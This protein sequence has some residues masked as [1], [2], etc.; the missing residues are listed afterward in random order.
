MNEFAPSAVRR[1]R[2]ALATIFFVNGAIFGSWAPHIPIV[3]ERLG[4]GPALLGAALLAIAIGALVTMILGGIVMG[5][6]GSAWP[7]QVST[8]AFCACL[9]LV[10]LAPSL[11]TLV[12]AF[13]AFGAANGIMDVAM[14]AHGV[15]VERRLGRAVMSSFHGMFSL[16]GLV[17]AGAGAVLLGRVDPT[18]HI[19][20]ATAVLAVLALPAV[21][22]LL[23]GRA[24]LGQSGAGFGLPTRT[25]FGLGALCFLAMM[26]E[27]AVL[28]W[29]AAYLREDLGADAGFA[30]SG[31]AAFSAAMA[32]AR[33]GGDGL[34]H[35]LG[36]VPLV[37]GSVLLAGGGLGLALLAGTPL[38]S[39]LG[40]ACAGLGLANAVPVLYGAAGRLPGELPATAIAAVATTGYLGFLAGPP[41]IGFA[42]EVSSLRVA[43]GILVVACALV[44]LFAR[45]AR[46]ADLA[47][48]TKPAAAPASC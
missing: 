24:D 15:A 41:L 25:T 31:F 3:Q 20:L 30:A 34:R 39:I 2:W 32:A 27:G 47:H 18:T 21:C 14:N 35:R 6:I 40:F 26:S 29:S 9:P 46:P 16:G 10:A 4:L 33:F 44:A 42:A 45:A 37:R 19:L 43:L 38:A 8:L 28:D 48:G 22:L 1:A 11:T 12:L 7:T 17:G 23:P 5:R 36:A 13:L